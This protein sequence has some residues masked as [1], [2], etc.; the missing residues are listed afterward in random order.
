[1][2]QNQQ[3]HF[4][5]N[6]ATQIMEAL[7]RANAGAGAPA[8]RSYSG[9]GPINVGVPSRVSSAA[10]SGEVPP[11]RTISPEERAELDAKAREL[12][13]MEK[14]E[15]GDD[16]Y[17]SMEAALAA[18]APVER[19]VDPMIARR[20]SVERMIGPAMFDAQRPSL[21]RAR[22]IDFKRVQSVDLMRGIAIVDDFEIELASVDVR[23][24]KKLVLDY[25]VNY[26]TRQLAEALLEVS[27][28]GI[29]G[30]EDVPSM[31]AGEADLA[32][33]PG[34]LPAGRATEPV[35]E[36]RPEEGSGVESGQTPPDPDAGSPPVGGEAPSA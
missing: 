14:D 28:D 23:A 8:G 3:A 11:P 29:D 1:M 35:Q 20:A 21:T 32:V 30:E 18:A 5:S 26:V 24:I 25:A 4:P 34:S 7:Q 22:L 2:S 6:P 16:K 19:P 13:I 10:M 12:G 36:V 27:Q 15:T 17:G 33:P 9:G 31:S